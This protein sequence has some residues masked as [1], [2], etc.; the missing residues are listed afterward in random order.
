MNVQVRIK[1][2]SL[3][4]TE[5]VSNVRGGRTGLMSRVG[6]RTARVLA[7]NDDSSF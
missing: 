5:L 2:L 6:L 3:T 4:S 7:T 1:F